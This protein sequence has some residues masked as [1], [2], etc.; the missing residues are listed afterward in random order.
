M[1]KIVLLVFTFL[2]TLCSFA[3]IKTGAEQTD[4]YLPQL[5]NKTVAVLV[6]HTATIK[7]THL[8]DSLLKLKIKVKKI[9]CPE[10]G[11]RGDADA[12]E[13]VK[14]AKDKKTGLPIV[15]LYGANKKPKPADL[16]G[17]DLVIFDIQDVGARFYTY[18]SSMHYMMEACAENNVE[19]I[20]LDRPN[21]NGFYIDG[22][23]L[24]KENK[25]FIGMHPIPIVHG[26]TIGELAQMING[27][28]W[29]ENSVKCKLTVVPCLN[30]THKTMYELPIKPSPNL[31]NANSILLYPSVCLFEGTVISVGRGTLQ[32]FEIIGHPSLSDTLYS[33]TPV[34]IEGASKNPPFKDQL[35]YGYKLC[36]ISD[37]I[38]SIKQLNLTYLLKVYNE[39]GDKPKFFTN[40]FR[41]LAGTDELQ[42]QIEQGLSEE[43]IRKSWK[44]EINVYKHLRKNYLLYE[45]FE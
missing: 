22:P 24:K 16:K 15:S 36:M 4:L 5:K 19:F 35:C 13:H 45:D 26:L 25:S 28:K 10:H 41:L 38:K 23:I 40:F 2:I 20:V 11:F 21:P 1:K 14:N 27:E 29:L 6:N 33:F 37:D 30:Y 9:F 34:A 8:V 42:K 17:I 12:G 32:P 7:Q 3:Q 39:F 31:P 18:I 44:R 43:E